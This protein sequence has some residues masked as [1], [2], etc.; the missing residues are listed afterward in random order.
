MRSYHGNALTANQL[1]QWAH[2]TES[3]RPFGRPFRRIIST[4]L[5][6]LAPCRQPLCRIT[7]RIFRRRLS[8]ARC[9]S[10]DAELESK[11]LYFP[12]EGVRFQGKNAGMQVRLCM[13]PRQYHPSFIVFMSA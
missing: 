5:P 10:P 3:W 12:V 11:D 4:F 6:F 1:N 7:M 13:T 2:N 9:S 8:M